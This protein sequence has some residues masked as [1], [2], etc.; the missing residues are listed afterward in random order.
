M[1]NY[2]LKGKNNPN[3][4]NFLINFVSCR[5]TATVKIRAIIGEEEEEEG[6]GEEEEEDQEEEE[7][8]G[9][10]GHIVRA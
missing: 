7:G 5:W 2:R 8:V 10:D 6:L 4:W 3:H 1:L 9:G